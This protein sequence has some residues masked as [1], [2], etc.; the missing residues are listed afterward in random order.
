MSLKDQVV[1]ARVEQRPWVSPSGI[2]I[3]MD[4][5]QHESMQKVVKHPYLMS[6][7]ARTSVS[8]TA[9]ILTRSHSSSVT[10]RGHDVDVFVF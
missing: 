5:P 2:R 10:Q 4:F 7:R 8:D 3:C 9:S 1:V 6:L